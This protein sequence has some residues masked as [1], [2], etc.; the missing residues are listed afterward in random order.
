MKW[1]LCKGENWRNLVTGLTYRLVLA[2]SAL[3]FT[4]TSAYPQIYNWTTIAGQAGTSGSADGTNTAAQFY[5]PFR[6]ALNGGNIYVADH[7]NFTVRRLKPIG[8]NWVVSTI[9]GTAGI[10]GSAD[11][12]NGSASFSYL[13]GITADNS[14]NLYLTDGG[15]NTIR[16]LKPSGTNWI[17]TTIAGLA[18]NPGS[19]DGTNNGAL[20]NFPNGIATDNSGILYVTDQNNRTIRKLRP[21]GTNWIVTT[22]AGLAGVNGSADGTNSAARFGS[23]VGISADIAGNLY[24]ADADTNTIRK[25]VPLGTNWVVTTIAGQ[26]GVSGTNDGI[27]GAAHFY[28]PYGTAEDGVGNVYV[29]DAGNSMIRKLTPSGNNWQ[30]TTIG[31]A[32]LQ[33]YSQDGT[34]TAARFNHANGVVA[35]GLGDVYVADTSDHTIRFG[36]NF[37]PPVIQLAI[38]LTNTPNSSSNSVKVSWPSPSTGLSLQ[39]NSNLRSTNWVTTGLPISDNGITRSVTFAPPTGN[40]FFRLRPN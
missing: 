2:I 22:I 20:F 6:L 4:Q 10:Q 32:P 36:Q 7:F 29:T 5:Y 34:N 35:D 9:A 26:A 30:V 11:G 15:S 25:M 40:L 16:K 21:S 24:L 37:S 23:P 33:S 3:L 12:T 1:K 31:G 38:Q 28:L 17:V 8:T 39:T 27:N 18:G 19:A 14:G 13:S